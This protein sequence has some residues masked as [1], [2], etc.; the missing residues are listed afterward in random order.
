MTLS[1]TGGAQPGVREEAVMLVGRLRV[2]VRRDYCDDP[3]CLGRQG[4]LEQ[5]GN[6]FAVTEIVENQILNGI[7]L[8]DGIQLLDGI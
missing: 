7:T 2:G 1:T 8:L 4:T 3:V 5:W 6:V